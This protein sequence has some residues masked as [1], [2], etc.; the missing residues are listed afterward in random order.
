MALTRLLLAWALVAALLAVWHEV[1]RRL[2]HSGAPLRTALPALAIEALLLALF[3]GL[4]FASLGHG[5]W[6]LL[7][8][9]VGALMELPPRL[10]DRG[11]RDLPWA[12]ALGGIARV[13]LAG[14][15]L[16]WRLG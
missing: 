14:G 2:T 4:W 7:F 1:G 12:A 5:G 15:I 10:R 16:A 11:L 9:L 13:V 3:A 8:A 6:G